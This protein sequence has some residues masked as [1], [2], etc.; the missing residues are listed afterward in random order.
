MRYDSRQSCV[1]ERKREKERRGTEWVCDW[2]R[3]REGGREGGGGDTGRWEF[4][5]C[6]C[7]PQHVPNGECTVRMRRQ[8]VAVLWIQT[9][10]PHLAKPP[11]HPPH[12]T[13]KKPNKKENPC[14][15]TIA[16]NSSTKKGGEKR[17]GDNA[18]KA[19]RGVHM[20]VD[21]HPHQQRRGSKAH[22][23]SNDNTMHAKRAP[24]GGGF[25][26]KSNAFPLSRVMEA[27]ARQCS[28]TI[29]K[30]KYLSMRVATWECSTP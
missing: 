27:V 8:D 10:V 9:G 3:E 7:L 20:H 4:A 21:S 23:E 30:E 14:V 6:M 26:V 13:Q 25:T 29:L 12:A 1:N 18:L 16:R 15:H 2:V 28:L 19:Q 11:T 5:L 22:T 17:P 24:G